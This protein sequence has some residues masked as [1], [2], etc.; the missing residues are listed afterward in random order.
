MRDFMEAI[1]RM[2]TFMICA[3][4]LIHFRPNGSYEKY[5]KLL[6]SVMVLVQ[7]F[8]PVVRLFAE[9]GQEIGERVEWFE[10]QIAQSRKEALESARES[11]KLLNDM[12][13]EE[14]EKNLQTEEKEYTDAEEINDRIER[15]KVELGE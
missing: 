6:V 3:Q 5:M 2:G 11:E 8:S 15:I 10:E 13:M 14:V 1:V 7:L 4:V 12:A 9:E